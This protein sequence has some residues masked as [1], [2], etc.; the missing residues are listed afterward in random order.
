MLKGKQFWILTIAVLIV[1]RILESV[2]YYLL[3]TSII[4]KLVTCYIYL[5]YK[6]YDV[7]QRLSLQDKFEIL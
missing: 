3:S 5:I 2:R 7:S 6:I 1:G 4:E